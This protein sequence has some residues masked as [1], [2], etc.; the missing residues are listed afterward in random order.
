MDS[1]VR[2]RETDGFAL[3]RVWPPCGL[4]V[5]TARMK[6]MSTDDQVPLGSRS[7]DSGFD[8]CG[9]I[10]PEG[11]VNGRLIAAGRALL[12]WDQLELAERAGIR[13]HTLADMENDARR[14]QSRVR[15]AVMDALENAGVRFIEVQ[16]SIGAVILRAHTTLSEEPAN[17]ARGD[18]TPATASRDSSIDR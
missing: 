3:R 9:R 16:G 5:V 7:S 14:P 15:K 12:G 13:R 6:A 18:C 1:R 11:L 10:I 17:Q 4:S 8:L 2:L